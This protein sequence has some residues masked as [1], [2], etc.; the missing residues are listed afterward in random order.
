MSKKKSFDTK[1]GCVTVI[2]GKL[3][4][5]V[6]K[7]ILFYLYA[8]IRSRSSVKHVVKC[9]NF[10]CF[11]HRHYIP[12]TGYCSWVAHYDRLYV[13]NVEYIKLF[14][15]YMDA[16]KNHRLGFRKTIRNEVRSNTF[17]NV[18]ICMILII[19]PNNIF[20][21]FSIIMK[22]NFPTHQLDIKWNKNNVLSFFD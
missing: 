13:G 4:R 11:V 19:L 10:G 2:S 18:I 8:T 12:W 9:R 7:V 3:G 14:Y 5:F 16:M 6:Y 15:L 21:F 20:R 22:K 1:D 17:Y